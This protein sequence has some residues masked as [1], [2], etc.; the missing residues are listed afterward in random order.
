LVQEELRDLP[1]HVVACDGARRDDRRA[2]A[3][4]LINDARQL[5]AASVVGPPPGVVGRALATALGAAADS[6]AV[7]QPKTPAFQLSGREARLAFASQ[8]LGVDLCTT[9]RKPLQAASAAA[10]TGA[11]STC[12]SRPACAEHG[13]AGGSVAG[14]GPRRPDF[15]RRVAPRTAC[16]HVRDVRGRAHLWAASRERKSEPPTERRPWRLPNRV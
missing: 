8:A 5:P 15:S 9:T 3:R 1:A 12:C 13:H 10:A 4:L 2:D 6:R 14:R 7:S 16:T 11:S